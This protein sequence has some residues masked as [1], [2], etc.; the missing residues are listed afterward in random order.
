MCLT[1]PVCRGQN[2]NSDPYLLILKPYL[3]DHL[4]LI[5]LWYRKQRLQAFRKNKMLAERRRGG[6]F[7]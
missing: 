2:W 4:L 3:L 5:H 6:D 1:Y 7:S